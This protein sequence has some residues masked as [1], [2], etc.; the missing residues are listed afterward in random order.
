MFLAP[1]PIWGVVD[2]SCASLFEVTKR[3]LYICMPVGKQ[4]GAKRNTPPNKVL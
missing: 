1:R 3:R 4:A 2:S